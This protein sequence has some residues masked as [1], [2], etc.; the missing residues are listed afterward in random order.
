[1]EL[2]KISRRDFLKLSASGALGFVLAELGVDRACAA[3]PTSQGRMIWSGISLNDAP[4]FKAKEIFRF[5]IDVV[6]ELKS[7]TQGDAGYGNPF[8]SVWY[9]IENGYA[10]SGWIQPVETKYQKPAYEIPAE[11]QLGEISV[12]MSETR[13]APYVNAKNG[14]RLYY[15]SVHWVKNIVVTRDEKSVWYEIFDNELKKSFYVPCYNMRLVQ[16][17]ELTLL[18]PNVPNAD[19]LIHVDLPTQTVTAFEGSTMVFSSRC[20]SG[21][22]GTRTP[23]GEFSTYHKSPSV[24]M[25]NQDEEGAKHYYHLPGVPWTSFFTGYGN[26][27]HGTYWHNDY[28]RPRSHGC[29]NLKSADA[30]WLYRWCLPTVPVG[31]DYLHLPGQG[32][33]VQ[34]V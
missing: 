27:F 3:P 8:N 9:Q 31:E 10:Y 4:S 19:K 17:A 13:L 25:T 21:G 14:Y 7:E 22:K 15:E 11:G 26:A 6:V 18:A 32:T 16:P 30:K 24:H 12:P 34:I 20:S 29:V 2:K 28:G 1:M 33:R 23:T 5:G